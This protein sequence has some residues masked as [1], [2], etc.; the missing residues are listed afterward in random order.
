MT[1]NFRDTSP[2]MLVPPCASAHAFY[3][4]RDGWR[5]SDFLRMV[6]IFARFYEYAGIEE[7][8]K[9]GITT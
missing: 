8:S 6:G 5:G 4:S 1:S 3:A 9:L 2:L 7:F